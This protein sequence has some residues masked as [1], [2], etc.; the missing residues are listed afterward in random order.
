[1]VGV[2]P[3]RGDTDTVPELGAAFITT[4]TVEYE[5]WALASVAVSLKVYVLPGVMALSSSF[6]AG[7]PTTPAA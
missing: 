3:S 1:V 2:V 4:E 6:I 5:A 7:A